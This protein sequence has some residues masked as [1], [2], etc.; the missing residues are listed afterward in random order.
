MIAGRPGSGKT[1]F[2][3][4]L[5]DRLTENQKPWFYFSLEMTGKS[6]SKRMMLSKAKV[7]N[8]EFRRGKIEGDGLNRIGSAIG[9][10]QDR[11]LHVDQT[12]ALSLS[13]LRSRL[14][15]SAVKHG[16]IG[17]IM[18]D[19]IG[20]IKKDVRKADTEG[21][22][23]IA[24]G[25]LELAK[26]FDC[27][28]VELCQLNRGVEGRQDKRPMI[29]DLKQSGK[30]EENADVVMLLYRD[31]YYDRDASP[32][33]EVNVAKNRDGAVDTHYFKHD[34]SIGHYE[35]LSDY[36]PPKEEPKGRRGKL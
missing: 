8:S 5:A 30:I 11:S 26:E 24:D 6:L 20:L 1:A 19:H 34:L 2:A 7:S 32:V 9:A 25:L 15:A 33:T 13:Q 14:K 3:L 28:L 36:A 23:M 35:D 31:D 10:I 4:S 22:N 21:M 27:P 12:P 16:R 17:G 18:I 29:S